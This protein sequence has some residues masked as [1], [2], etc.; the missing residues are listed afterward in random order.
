MCK[1]VLNYAELDEKV[2]LALAKYNNHQRFINIKQN[3]SITQK[4]EF[5][6]VYPWEVMKVIEVL[7]ASKSTSRDIPLT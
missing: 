7:D 5:S 1:E 2:S 3:I 6:H 4:F